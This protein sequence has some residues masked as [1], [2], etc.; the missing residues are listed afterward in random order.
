MQVSG[1]LW[2]D[3]SNIHS[4][5]RHGVAKLVNFPTTGLNLN[6]DVIKRMHSFLNAE[7]LENNMYLLQHHFY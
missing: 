1:W 5:G 3:R 4:Q 2:L 6:H 7:I